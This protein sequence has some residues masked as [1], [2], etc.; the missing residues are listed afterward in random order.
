MFAAVLERRHSGKYFCL[1]EIFSWKVFASKILNLQLCLNI[2]SGDPANKFKRAKRTGTAARGE[3]HLFRFSLST[4]QHLS[5][6]FLAAPRQQKLIEF[7]FSCIVTLI[8]RKQAECIAR[9]RLLLTP[10]CLLALSLRVTIKGCR[11]FRTLPRR[12]RDRVV[13]HY[14]DCALRSGVNITCFWHV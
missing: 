1:V 12:R 3:V 13:V 4:S 9:A 8:Y 5:T 10:C 6:C 7:C 2:K 14:K 11:G